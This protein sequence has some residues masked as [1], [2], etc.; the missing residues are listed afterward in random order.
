MTRLSAERPYLSPKSMVG[1]DPLHTFMALA[2][3]RPGWRLNV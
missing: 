1:I 2:M 3:L